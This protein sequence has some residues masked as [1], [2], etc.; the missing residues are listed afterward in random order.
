MGK[1]IQSN[2]DVETK[3][4][5]LRDWFHTLKASRTGFNGFLSAEL[6]KAR[7]GFNFFFF[8]FFFFY[9][10]GNAFRCESI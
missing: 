2:G 5:G 10:K 4:R 3:C 9:I 8:F 6:Y 1:M 7:N